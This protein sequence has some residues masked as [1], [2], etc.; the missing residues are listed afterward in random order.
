MGEIVEFE[1]E[2]LLK[3]GSSELLEQLDDIPTLPVVAIQVNDLLGDP[4]SSAADVARVMKRDQALT[5]KVLKL[6]NSPYYGIPGGVTDIQRALAYLGF[7]TMG[8]IILSLSVFSVF[9]LRG[10]QEFSITEFW[11]HA[12]AVALASELIAK[13]TKV[14]R[15]EEAFTCG[16]LHDLGKVVLYKI[17]KPTLHAIVQKAKKEETS[18]VEAESALGVLS[19]TYF[20]EVIAQKWKLPMVIQNAI[21]YHHD[22]KVDGYDTVPKEH[23]KVIHAVMLADA[24]VKSLEVGD[25]G[26]GVVQQVPP[27][28]LEKVGADSELLKEL[29]KAL[30]DEM[31]RAEDFIRYAA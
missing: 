23:K 28:L 16:L 4:D 10:S 30:F 25:S 31:D 24:Y 13:K 2:K 21:H 11:K 5:A 15:P 18:F 1:N 14:C 22:P 9:E 12:L 29:E 6:V 19:H 7:N 3:E 26:D 20:G 27:S 8:Q 17:H